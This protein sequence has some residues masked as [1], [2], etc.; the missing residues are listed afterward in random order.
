MGVPARVPALPRWLNLTLPLATPLRLAEAARGRPGLGRPRPL[1]CPRASRGSGRSPHSRFCVTVVNE[2]G[3]AM[4]TDC[5]KRAAGP[6]RGRLRQGPPP[7]E[8]PEWDTRRG[9]AAP[10]R[11]ELRRGSSP[12]GRQGRPGGPDS[13]SSCCPGRPR[14]PRGPVPGT[15]WA[16]AHRHDRPAHEPG[17]RLRTPDPGPCGHVLGRAAPATP[18][19]LDLEPRPVREGGR[20]WCCCILPLLLQSGFPCHSMALAYGPWLVRHRRLTAVLHTMGGD[21]IWADVSVSMPGYPGSTRAL[22]GIHRRVSGIAAK[23][24]LALW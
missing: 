2:Q 1:P 19:R 8:H 23:L 6:Q 4:P 13:G 12:G 10:T 7:A 9:D 3:H 5:C 16:S 15:Q 24:V 18:G 21:P 11:M 17:D 20:T 22:S 14:L